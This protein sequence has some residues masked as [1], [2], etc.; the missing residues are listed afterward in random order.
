MTQLLL[1]PRFNIGAVA[2][3]IVRPCIESVLA[4]KIPKRQALHMLGFYIPAHPEAGQLDF[5]DC[6]LFEDSITTDPWS[7]DYKQIARSKGAISW[8]TGLD[9]DIIQMRAP[10]LLDDRDTQYWGSRVMYN[11]GASCSGNEPYFDRMFSGW[12][13]EAMIALSARARASLL[14]GD[15]APD[16][17]DGTSTAK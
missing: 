13:V 7:A 11:I 4:S 12:F 8:N 15:P 6:I 3:R 2:L 5:T 1:S 16:F 10:H 9:S 14:A 17:L